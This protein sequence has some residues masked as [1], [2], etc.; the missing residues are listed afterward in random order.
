MLLNAKKAW[1]EQQEKWEEE[2][3]KLPKKTREKKKQEYLKQDKEDPK[4]L[5]QKLELIDLDLK[6]EVKLKECLSK[7]YFAHNFACNSILNS[8][9]TEMACV[10]A[11]F[12]YKDS[13]S[14]LC[15]SHAL[16]FFS[17]WITVENETKDNA[18]YIIARSSDTSEDRR[19]NLSAALQAILEK[20]GLKKNQIAEWLEVCKYSISA[21]IN[22]SAVFINRRAMSV[23]ASKKPDDRKRYMQGF[24][25]LVA[26]YFISL[27][28]MAL[29]FA[30]NIKNSE[31]NEESEEG[32]EFEEYTESEK[33]EDNTWNENVKTIKN[34]VA[35][36]TYSFIS[37][38]FGT[39]KTLNYPFLIN[40]YS[41]VATWASNTQ[42][43]LEID[44]L[45]SQVNIKAKEPT[46]LDLMDYLCN[47]IQEIAEEKDKDNKLPIE[48]LIKILTYKNHNS[49]FIRFLNDPKRSDLNTI[50]TI[51][52]LI[53]LAKDAQDDV[54]NCWIKFKDKCSKEYLTLIME[55]ASKN[56]GI[57][58]IPTGDNK[59]FFTSTLQQAAERL[60]SNRKLVAMSESS[61]ISHAI[62]GNSL[63]NQI[64]PKVIIVIDV[65]RKLQGER[66][67]S[68]K[69][70]EISYREIKGYR[71][72]YN[73]LKRC[74][75]SSVNERL[76]AL[77]RFWEKN[78]NDSG[79]YLFLEY[80]CKCDHVPGNPNSNFD[81][82]SDLPPE[83]LNKYFEARSSLSKAIRHKIPMLHHFDP[84]TSPSILRFGASAMD[85]KHKDFNKDNKSVTRKMFL[86]LWNGEKFEK[87]IEAT[88]VS[89]R[90]CD[91]FALG[92]DPNDP[93]VP[94]ANRQGRL[95]AHLSPDADCQVNGLNE[96]VPI[97]IIPSKDGLNKLSCYI[98][99]HNISLEWDQL[100][101]LKVNCAWQ[102]N[103]QF[104]VI[105]NGPFI[106][107]LIE[108]NYD[109]EYSGKWN[110]FHYPQNNTSR[111]S[112]IKF[113]HNRLP[114]NTTGMGI[115]IGLNN[116]LAIAIVTTRSTEDIVSICNKAG[117]DPPKEDDLTIHVPRGEEGEYR[118]QDT[119]FIRLGPDKLQDGT[120]YPAPWAEIRK[121]LTLRLPGERD[122]DKRL[123][124]IDEM[125][126]IHETEVSLGISDPYG[127]RLKRSGFGSSNKFSNQEKILSE[128]GEKLSID[129]ASNTGPVLDSTTESYQR[130][131]SRFAITAYHDLTYVVR[132][133]LNDL[134]AITKVFE[135]L[136]NANVAVATNGMRQFWYLS[137]QD[138]DIGRM[139]KKLW[140]TFVMKLEGYFEPKTA[141][142]I[143]DEGNI[144]DKTTLNEEVQ[145]R[146]T[147]KTSLIAEPFK[148]LESS[149]K[150]SDL[151]ND[152]LTS[153]K[154][155]LLQKE[156][157]IGEAIETLRQALFH[158]KI[159][160]NKA[161]FFK[162]GGLSLERLDTLKA[163]EYKL[164]IPFD[165]YKHQYSNAT[166]EYQ[167]LENFKIDKLSQKEISKIQRIADARLELQVNYALR[168]SQDDLKGIVSPNYKG[169]INDPN[170][171]NFCQFIV[172]EN[173]S[174]LRPSETRTRRNNKI[175]STLRPS[176]FRKQLISRCTYYGIKVYEIDPAFTSILDSKYRIPGI[177]VNEISAKNFMS[178]PWIQKQVLAA[179]ERALKNEPLPEEELLI[180]NHEKLKG[181]SESELEKAPDVFII[182]K[183]GK[184]FVSPSSDGLMNAD[185]NAAVNIA[186]KA[187]I[188]PDFTGAHIRILTDKNGI[189][190]PKSYK[191][192]AIIK[193]G[194]AH[195]LIS[196]NGEKAK[197]QVKTENIYLYRNPSSAAINSKSRWMRTWE[198]YSRM[199]KNS[200]RRII[201]GKSL[202]HSGSGN[203]P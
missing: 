125:V 88:W 199:K 50:I 45:N 15:Q 5:N 138:S 188:D 108:H 176:E 11:S 73:Y 168:A 177:R 12:A 102:V 111:G 83:E 59:N 27:E 76:E 172:I 148:F 18:G 139:A 143:D 200:I 197:H 32:E 62:F 170:P 116:A 3:N 92:S 13:D 184:L 67:N 75:S 84:F 94:L 132:N 69:E 153:F 193:G 126:R 104:K 52:E 157:I 68:K 134:Y 185:M 98:E 187:L 181:L 175:I 4:G 17:L 169:V 121:K 81:L 97:T 96:K 156:K 21:E 191:G 93:V 166:G 192:S 167:S 2:L 141:Q 58:F 196:E 44:P 55:K 9:L 164:I 86:C 117:V 89:D 130:K 115:D 129:F 33:L 190:D 8:I 66:T 72:F 154:E 165:K 158:H 64:S 38:R 99:R 30:P 54:E 105:C 48:K 123:L 43:S 79:S 171:F 10:P 162:M 203:D 41:T 198:F 23:A 51:K 78:A 124:S 90:A 91:L 46:I 39:G 161:I 31:K 118:K 150:K 56:C 22:D 35:K 144:D 186:L 82:L 201:G 47:S 142:S 71:N 137:Q 95:S 26:Y 110:N 147:D 133:A 19:S 107:W 178:L 60:I 80:L 173:L 183:G 57:P 29:E 77:S 120:K 146:K 174:T 195:K 149:L 101:N 7:T 180:A 36:A 136:K 40:I 87:E 49:N 20:D 114:P 103:F 6:K 1:E 70:Y 65:Y 74:K 34:F 63:L 25:D 109:I 113:N 16:L 106:E 145:R 119:V 28:K 194:K 112:A 152:F 160:K 179:K 189:P 42:K 53:K 182:S 128:M 14:K 163:L 159:V 131:P 85:V 61:R 135:E 140:E 155:A 127:F 122:G 202:D 100:I 151:Y 24:N 37:K